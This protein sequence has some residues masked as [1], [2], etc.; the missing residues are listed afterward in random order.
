[1]LKVI[2]RK[3]YNVVGGEGG[4]WKGTVSLADLQKQSLL[5]TYEC[6][7]HSTEEE[8]AQVTWIKLPLSYSSAGSGT[9][10]HC[11]VFFLFFFNFFL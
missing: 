3:P 8:A 6:K 9:D 5:M 2:T 11:G 10:A 1:M 4:R 7:T